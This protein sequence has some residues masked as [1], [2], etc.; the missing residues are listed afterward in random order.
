MVGQCAEAEV[1]RAIPEYDGWYEVSDR[2]RVRSLDRTIIRRDGRPYRA[3][4]R[5]L[6]PQRH[7]PSWVVTVTLARRGHTLNQCVHKLVQAAFDEK[8]SAA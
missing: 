2:G 5:V 1:W 6:R 3:K 7:R 8:E 4:G